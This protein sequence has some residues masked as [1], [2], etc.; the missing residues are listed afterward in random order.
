LTCDECKKLFYHPNAFALHKRHHSTNVTKTTKSELKSSLKVPKIVSSIRPTRLFPSSTPCKNTAQQSKP[1]IQ[2]FKSS[3]SIKLKAVPPFASAS[4]LEI[5]RHQSTINIKH[6]PKTPLRSSSLIKS[7]KDSPI[8]ED[9]LE[10]KKEKTFFK[11]S[12]IPERLPIKNKNQ[13]SDIE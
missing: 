9:S 11:C 3:I 7:R 2:R 10:N 8:T 1:K 6:L 4:P 5:K 13:S 12:V